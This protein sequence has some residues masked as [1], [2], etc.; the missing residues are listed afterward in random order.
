[1]NCCVNCSAPVTPHAGRGAQAHYCGVPCRRAAEFRIRSLTRLLTSLRF[2]LS[3]TRQFEPGFVY[4]TRGGI[5]QRIAALESEIG[6]AEAQLH[7][8]LAACA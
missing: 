5:D 2:R 3:A 8:L 6:L 1:M 7:T 4:G